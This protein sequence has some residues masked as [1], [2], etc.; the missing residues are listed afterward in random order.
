MEGDRGGAYTI[1]DPILEAGR[2]KLQSFL[3]ANLTHNNFLGAHICLIFFDIR[4]KSAVFNILRQ[5]ET[6]FDPEMD[7]E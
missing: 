3:A 1:L 5:D 4:D 2:Q 7:R 6:I